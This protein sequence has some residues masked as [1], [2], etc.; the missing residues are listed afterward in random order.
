MEKLL[1]KPE[2]GIVYE[3]LKSKIRAQFLKFS[4]KFLAPS[5]RQ[6]VQFK[7]VSYPRFSL[8]ISHLNSTIPYLV[9][10]KKIENVSLNRLSIKKNWSKL[11]KELIVW[12]WTFLSGMLNLADLFLAI[13]E[14]RNQTFLCGF[15]I[16]SYFFNIT[17][18]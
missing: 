1:P 13:S 14:A 8:E 6:K 9:E 10:M 17:Y 11:T 15:K 5:E 2:M 12:S 4:Y 16:W 3:V 7:V 18:I